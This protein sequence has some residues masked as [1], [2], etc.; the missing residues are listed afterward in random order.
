LTSLAFL[1]AIF[2]FEA[3][4]AQGIRLPLIKSQHTARFFQK[5]GDVIS[6]IPDSDS[7]IESYSVLI[8]LGTPPEILNVIVDTGSSDLIVY[9]SQCTGCNSPADYVS[10]NSTSSS[11][12]NCHTAGYTCEGC[13]SVNYCDTGNSYA[14]G[15]TF[16]GIAYSDMF[17]VGNLPRVHASFSVI[18]NVTP[19][20]GQSP[21]GDGIQGL[22][23]VAYKGLAFTNNTIFD[24]LVAGGLQ[25]SFS[26]CLGGNPVMSLGVDYSANTSYYWTPIIQQDWY[27]VNLTSIAIGGT[28]LNIALIDLSDCIVASGTTLLY[29][30]PNAYNA[31]VD[32]ITAT[33][34]AANPLVGIYNITNP[35]DNIF[36]VNLN[37]FSMTTDQINAY[38]TI[39]F[40]MMGIST[41][42]QLPPSDYL[43]SYEDPTQ[44]TLQC[45]GFQLG[46]DNTGTVLGD[47]FMRAFHVVFDR[48]NARIGF[49]SISTCP[50][51][52][53]AVTT[54]A[55]PPPAMVTTAS[56]YVFGTTASP[57]SSGHTARWM[58]AFV[59]G[60]MFILF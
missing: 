1:I 15:Q 43:F 23:G 45:S 47:V 44:G 42:L 5:R 40:T 13:T 41:P 8:T 51:P 31:V 38:P 30:L 26:M 54:A 52:P 11:I 18:Y 35:D 14:S 9:G 20:N 3:V 7:S 50:T 25:N 36:G 60:M 6:L 46:N 16:S 59:A 29:L 37:C 49:G 27:Q 56:S 55:I 10:S 2:S 19:D 4:T 24:A 32:T 21:F 33:S 57:V 17:G 58:G 39:S 22:W 28:S 34:N 12:V 48:A 53:P